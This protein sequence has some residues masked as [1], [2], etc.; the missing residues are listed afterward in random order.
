MADISNT[1]F[2]SLDFPILNPTYDQTAYHDDYKTILL[3]L[4]KQIKSGKFGRETWKSNDNIITVKR[5]CL[6]IDFLSHDLDLIEAD[7]GDSE[8]GLLMETFLPVCIFLKIG[9]KNS[10]EK[11]G[12]KKLKKAEKRSSFKNRKVALNFQNC[13]TEKIKK[14]EP[15]KNEKSPP[16]LST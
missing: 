11:W 8:F 15:M 3:D 2:S 4:N 1:D 6:L 13:E 14:F 12:R 5:V 7:F 9:S 10:V 16:H